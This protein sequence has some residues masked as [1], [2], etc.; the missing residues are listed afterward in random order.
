[1]IAFSDTRQSAHA[2]LRELNNG[3]W[4]DYAEVPARLET[5]RAALG[6]IQE[7]RDHGLEPILAVHD[8]GYVEFLRTAHK[9]WRE[10]GRDGDAIGYT[11]P[12]VHRRKLDLAR[13]DGA[14]G[15]Y[16]MDA[17]T[18]IAAETWDAAYW[19]AQSALTALDA[20]ADGAPHA[21][22]L[23]RPPGHHA[24]PDYMGG[25]CYLNSAAIAAREAMARGAGPVA[26]FDVDYHH[27]NGTQDIFRE[28]GEVLF[29]SIHADPSNDFP[30][31]W[32][33]AD[34]EGEGEGQGA[35]LN[36]PLPRGT[37]WEGY[38]P[39]LETACERI[40]GFG[41]K[42]LIVSYGADT[43]RDDP[44]SHLAL[45]TDDY[46]RMGERI[47]TL[48]LPSVIVM[49]GGYDLASLGPNVKRFCE[50]FEGLT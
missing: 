15:T 17:A 30:Y 31:F 26:V 16:A 42:T 9:R 47:A 1:M 27:G 34:E 5:I 28:D 7:A 4:M 40:A 49:E 45:D 2:P 23:C 12:V 39:A 46:R 18:P 19:S 22:A 13:I 37:C 14:L 38:G 44:I 41:A 8:A 6:E 50:G 10:T 33:H 25:Y 35:T 43:H 48:G 20:V 21:L 36:L 11:F 29:V 3:E 24:G 32:G